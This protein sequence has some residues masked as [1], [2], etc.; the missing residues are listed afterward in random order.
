MIRF[1]EVKTGMV[2]RFRDVE[3]VA[4]GVNNDIRHIGITVFCVKWSQWPFAKDITALFIPRM[5]QVEWIGMTIER[6]DATEKEL[7]TLTGG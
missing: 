5:M 3:Y 7:D 2:I 4:I 6:I 1:D